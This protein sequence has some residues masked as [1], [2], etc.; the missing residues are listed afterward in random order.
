MGHT[1]EWHGCQCGA[2]FFFGERI[3]PGE[4]VDV[5]TTS[6]ADKAGE[7]MTDDSQTI[8]DAVAFN[9]QHIYLSTACL[10]AKLTTI[11]AEAEILHAYCRASTV[12]RD[13]DWSRLGPSYLSDKDDPKTP[14]VCKICAT[15]CVCDC[16]G[17]FPST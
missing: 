7:Q 8:I 16:H 10:H 14:A 9:G 13:G 5:S 1:R 2:E 6:D 4:K 3:D 17:V 11:P 12:S 15:R